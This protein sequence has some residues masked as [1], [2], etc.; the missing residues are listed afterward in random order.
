M[1]II[2]AFNGCNLGH[3]CHINIL[4]LFS[5]ENFFKTY[6]ISQ[7]ARDAYIAVLYHPDLAFIISTAAQAT[8]PTIRDAENLNDAI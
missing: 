3:D 7:N 4:R 2:K 8:E 1:E 5:L 6:F